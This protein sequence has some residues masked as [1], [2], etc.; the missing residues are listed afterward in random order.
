L[1]THEHEDPAGQKEDWKE[2]RSV[3]EQLY[4]CST[5]DS[6][7]AGYVWLKKAQDIQILI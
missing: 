3:T 1:K 2:E 4:R 6:S 7:I 5:K